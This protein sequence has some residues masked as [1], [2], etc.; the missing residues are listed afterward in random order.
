MIT[1]P[2]PGIPLRWTVRLAP[3][4]LVLAFL[5]LK[6]LRPAT[7]EGMVQEGALAENL[8]FCLYGA[9]ALVAVYAARRGGADGKRL[10]LLGIALALV[11]MEEISWGQ[12]LFGFE[13]PPWFRLHNAQGEATI[14]NL[15]PVQHNLLQLQ[16]GVATV[17][18]FGWL[19]RRIPAGLALCCPRKE[20]FLYFAPMVL[21]YGR[22]VLHP[23]P[24]AFMIW[25]DQE[26]AELLMALGLLLHVADLAARA[27]RP[28][29]DGTPCRPG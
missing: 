16:L 12:R 5:A 1:A 28:D 7:Y 15:Y 11:A 27:R 29:G 6:F 4:A 14:H 3:L 18:T 8:Q 23:Q 13:T 24:G 19:V 9:A 17:L 22:F 10:L 25:R 21:V 20:L 26:P 2:H